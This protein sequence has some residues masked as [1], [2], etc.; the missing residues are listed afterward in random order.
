MRAGILPRRYAKALFW[1]ARER[2][3]QDKIHQDW[4]V[5]VK[6]LNDKPDFYHF[7]V[8]PEVARKE[9]EEK[10]EELFG[11]T[12]SNV[13]YNFLLVLLRNRRQNLILEISDAFNVEV[14]Q[15]VNRTKAIVTSA[16]ELTPELRAEIEQQLSEKLNKE[17][18]LETQ[19]DPT[20]I[21]GI[22]IM[23]EGKVID[24]SIQGRLHMM[25]N[26]LMRKSEEVTN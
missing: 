23:V 9:K 6:A 22:R 14:D 12:F 26:F 7:F 1:V 21:G 17:V 5:F 4:S 19:I 20:L 2:G 18:N 11:D 15:S 16:V 8:S 3:I 25:K 24:G 13:F 10:I